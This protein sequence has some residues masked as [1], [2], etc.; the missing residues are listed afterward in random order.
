[1]IVYEGV[2]HFGKGSGSAGWFRPRRPS[3]Y[4]GL[5]RLF[6]SPELQV[7]EQAAIYGIRQAGL[8]SGCYCLWVMYCSFSSGKESLMCMRGLQGQLLSH[9]DGWQLV[10]LDLESIGR[11]SSCTSGTRIP[12]RSLNKREAHF[13]WHLLLKACSNRKT[14]HFDSS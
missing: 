6:F 14:A 3:S 9:D 8:Y 2:T 13:K 7:L 10:L 1:M 5:L 4:R 12:D 11:R